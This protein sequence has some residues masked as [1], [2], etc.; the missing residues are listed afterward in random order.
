MI[1]LNGTPETKN[2]TVDI[3]NTENCQMAYIECNNEMEV[4]CS[5]ENLRQFAEDIITELDALDKN[6]GKE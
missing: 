2:I 4:E 3:M 1:T 5:R 6:G